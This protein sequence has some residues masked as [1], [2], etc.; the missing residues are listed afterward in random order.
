[1]AGGMC[2]NCSHWSSTDRVWGYCTQI[3]SDYPNA[4]E[5]AASI[6]LCTYDG[7]ADLWTREDFGCR[8]WS[9]LKVALKQI[10]ALRPDPQ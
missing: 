2:K 9:S 3:V 5:K 8:A 10:E 1:M 6:N 7:S 4:L